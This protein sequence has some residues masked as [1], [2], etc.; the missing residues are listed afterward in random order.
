MKALLRKW[1]RQLGFYQVEPVHFD[2]EQKGRWKLFWGYH[3]G[4]YSSQNANAEYFE[5][6]QDAS[7][8]Y[9]RQ[10]EHLLRHGYFIWFA[11][12]YT[13]EG[14]QLRL[15]LSTPYKRPD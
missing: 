9:S 15:D 8:Y 3:R 1:M 4:D 11:Y 7:D 5:T 13:P 14:K 12:L 2:P 10:K 6:E